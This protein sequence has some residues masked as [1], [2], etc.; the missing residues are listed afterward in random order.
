M[1]D[2]KDI[3]A[4]FNKMD[5]EVQITE[6]ACE[7]LVQIPSMFRGMALKQMLKQAKEKGVKTVDLAFVQE[8]RKGSGF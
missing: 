1:A 2:A 4:E 6:E 7:P 3:M 8:V 5:P